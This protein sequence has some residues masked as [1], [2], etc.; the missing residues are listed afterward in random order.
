MNI[1]MATDTLR[2][3][4]KERRMIEL[5]KGLKK[6]GAQCR[7]IILSDLI[8]YPEIYEV[9][10]PIDTIK[11][12][13]KRDFSVFGKIFK[14][15]REF[16]PDIVHSWE[17]MTSIYMLPIVKLLRIAFV[18][19]MVSDAPIGLTMSDAKWRRAKLTF[20]FSDAIIA[21]SKAGLQAYGITKKGHCFYN[22]FDFNRIKQL[23][24]KQGIREALGIANER[25]VGMV[26]TFSNKK[27]YKTFIQA[28]NR[29]LRQYQDVVFMAIGHGPDMEKTR[30]L[31]DEEIQHRFIFTGHRTDVEDIVNIFDIGV[32]SSPS[33]GISN[34]IMEYMAL[35]KPVVA[36][37]TGGTVE[38]VQDDLSGFLVQKNSPE[39]MIDRIEYLLCHPK[40]ADRMGAKG[41][42]IIEEK[43]NLESMTK[44]YLLLYKTLINGR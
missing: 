27:D 1:L 38:L 14:I 13:S 40:E 24:D 22:G 25:V 37:A 2:S 43:F 15:V 9:G 11:R 3:G 8:Q 21:N 18:N 6:S 44:D 42:S 29:L 20:P 31:V 35:S 7:V 12:T 34:S 4:G 19:A 17:S 23:A 28:G 16:K 32:L 5:L 36:S 33:E 39:E 10:Y 26:G 30:S 41:R